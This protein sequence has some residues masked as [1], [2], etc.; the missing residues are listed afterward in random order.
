MY[1]TLTEL[2]NR[3]RIGPEDESED[4]LN[5]LLEDASQVIDDEVGQPLVRSTDTVT[6]DGT[7]GEALLLPRWPVHAVDDVVL[8]DEDGQEHVLVYRGDYTWSASGVLTRRPHG[9]LWPCHDRAVRAT[10]TA[11][12]ELED[13][14]RRVR[15][16]C[17]R[18]AAAGRRNPAGADSEDIGDTRVR[19]NTP[20][21]LLTTGERELLARYARP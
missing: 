3:L 13:I 1:A 5:E 7:G 18:L 20:G 11:G 8:V 19:W 16:I 10:Y 15:R 6:L 4:A 17:L 2:R 21:M 9:R 14:A 12:Y